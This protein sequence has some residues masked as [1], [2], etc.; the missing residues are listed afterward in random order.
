MF[1]DISCTYQYQRRRLCNLRCKNV[2][3][4]I[5]TEN[6]N[7]GLRILGLKFRWFILP[8]KI[9]TRFFQQFFFAYT[10]LILSPSRSRKQHGFQWKIKH[11]YRK[12][13]LLCLSSAQPLFPR[14]SC[15]MFSDAISS[16]FSSLKTRRIEGKLFKQYI[17]M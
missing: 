3:V 2:Y 15:F 13:L 16:T 6:Y 12:S 5:K 17:F 10:T 14:S 9:K 8:T 1:C 11:H 7:S 4:S